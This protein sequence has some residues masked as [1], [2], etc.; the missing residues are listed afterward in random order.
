ME[1]AFLTPNIEFKK[2]H[3]SNFKL[4]VNKW[5]IFKAVFRLWQ[6]APYIQS[7]L[8]FKKESISL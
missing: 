4:L 1:T 3:D 6:K 5:S 7:D 2:I 8:K